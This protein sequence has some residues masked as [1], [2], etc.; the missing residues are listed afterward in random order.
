L[1]YIIINIIFVENLL[2]NLK[3]TK[4]KT[5]R[6]YTNGKIYDAISQLNKMVI[7]FLENTDI[8]FV[9]L[10]EHHFIHGTPKNKKHQYETWYPALYSAIENDNGFFVKAQFRGDT[11][12]F[13]FELQITDNEENNYQSFADKYWTNDELNNFDNETEDDDDYSFILSNY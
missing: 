10:R 3:F 6:E 12:N 7:N 8:N 13:N 5:I 9:N 11:C 1:F 2:T 4:M